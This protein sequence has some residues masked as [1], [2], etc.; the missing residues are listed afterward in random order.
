MFYFIKLNAKWPFLSVRFLFQRIFITL[1]WVLIYPQ[2]NSFFSASAIL[3]TIHVLEALTFKNE[4]RVWWPRATVHI[5]CMC[6]G[7]WLSY[8]NKHWIIDVCSS[9]ISFYFVLKYILSMVGIAQSDIKV[10]KKN[11]S[12]KKK[13]IVRMVRVLKLL[14]TIKCSTFTKWHKSLSSFNH[15]LKWPFEYI[16]HRFILCHLCGLN[17]FRLDINL[18]SSFVILTCSLWL[19][20]MW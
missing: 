9:C 16:S 1:K 18:N 7:I 8:A 5:C 12:N 13:R 10:S 2:I 3:H 19:V 14:Q 11:Y 6:A 20:D 4:S 17:K 15:S